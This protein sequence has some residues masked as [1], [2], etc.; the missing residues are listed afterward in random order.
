LT[1]SSGQAAPLSS[2]RANIEVRRYFPAFDLPIDRRVGTDEPLLIA[3]A[4]RGIRYYDQLMRLAGRA[5][6]GATGLLRSLI[7][8][9]ILVKWVE[10]SRR[11]RIQMYFVEDDLSRLRMSDEWEAVRRS[12]GHE[13]KP[14]FS[15]TERRLLERRAHLLRRVAIGRRERIGHRDRDPLMPNIRARADAAGEAIELY[16]TFIL[17]SQQVHATGRTVS[18]DEIEPRPTGRHIRPRSAMQ[19]EP[20]RGL[21]VPAICF[22]LASISR[23]LGLGLDAELDDLRNR[24]TYWSS[25]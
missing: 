11:L 14:A 25:P 4:L 7:D 10:G 15:A 13:P 12:R 2:S 20:I 21:A 19:A 16:F 9:A 23:Q 18:F 5:P 22:L 17:L 24:V 3:F 6:D 1:A 8:L